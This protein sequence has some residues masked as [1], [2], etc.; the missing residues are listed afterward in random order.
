MKM[1]MRNQKKRSFVQ[2]FTW[3]ALIPLG[4]GLIFLTVAI[5]MQMVPLNPE[6]MNVY[7]NGIRQPGTAETVRTFR[8]IFLFVFGGLGLIPMIVGLVMLIRRGVKN[9]LHAR[10]KQEGAMLWAEETELVNSSVRINHRR[11]QYL[12]CS[13]NDHGRAYIFKSPLLRMDPTP[14]LGNGKVKVYYDRNDMRKHYVD[15][16]GSI[17]NEVE[18]FDFS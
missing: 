17:E 4:L 3:V 10:L 8:M 11:L 16:D 18:V 14:F 7:I 1:N 12:R 5:V 6:N 2:N 15:I 13:Y 9:K